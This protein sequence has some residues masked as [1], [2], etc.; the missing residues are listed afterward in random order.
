MK[1]YLDLIYSLFPVNI[2]PSDIKSP[3]TKEILNQWELIDRARG[4]ES[5]FKEMSNTIY[6]ELNCVNS[7]D[8]S[9]RGIFDLCRKVILFLPIDN[10]NEE[11]PYCVVNISVVAKY[12]CVY[13]TKFYG[14]PVHTLNRPISKHQQDMIDHH[15]VPIIKKYYPGYE[16]FPMEYFNEKVPNV[17]SSINFDEYATYF[18]CLLTDDIL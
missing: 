18:E 7:M 6:Q 5:T 11:F 13:F 14:T 8:F 9:L 10:R 4:D 17:Y 16:E 15:I 12:Y 3:Y 2:Y 1:E